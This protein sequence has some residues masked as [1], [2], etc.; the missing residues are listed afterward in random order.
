MP[1][2]DQL[3]GLYSNVLRNGQQVGLMRFQEGDQRRQQAHI[4]RA[5]AQLVCPD[6]GQVEEPPRPL[7]FAKR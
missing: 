4:A 1:R 5:P 3:F 7:F 2:R 6:S